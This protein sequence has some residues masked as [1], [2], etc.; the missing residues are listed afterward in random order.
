VR[1]Y[2][3]TIQRWRRQRRSGQIRCDH[4]ANGRIFFHE[5]SCRFANPWPG[6]RVQFEI[7]YDEGAQK[8]RA[9]NVELEQESK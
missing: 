8:F 3:G 7:A 2:R 1:L 4:P 9:V 6:M 5:E